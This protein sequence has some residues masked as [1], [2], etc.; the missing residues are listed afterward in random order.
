[1]HRY[2]FCPAAVLLACIAV[3]GA[4][5]QRP[6]VLFIAVDD[7]N[8]WVGVLGGHPQAKTPNIDRLA[9][10]GMLFT[11]AYC[12]APLCNPSRT[13][14]MTG[15]RP[16]TSGVHGNQQDW[17]EQPSLQG[18]VTLPQYFR[19]HGYRTLGCGKLYHANH[20]G[21]PGA[22][23]GWHGGRQGFNHPASWD[24]RFPS[25][26]VQLPLSSVAPGQ[27]YNGLDIWHWDW[28][29]IG[30]P[31]SAT[32]DG[33]TTAWAIEQLRK[34]H[35]RPFFLAVGIYRP[36]GPWYVPGAYFEQHPL[37]KTV[38][39]TVEPDD[40]KDIPAAG[41]R[42]LRNPNHLHKRILEHDLWHSA[43]QAYLANITFADAML[44]RVLDAL[45]ESG[46]RDNTII[47]LWSD[48]GWHLGEKQ[49]WHKSTLWEEAARV[50]LIFV[51]PGTTEPGS[52]CRR[53]VSLVDLYPTLVELCGLP[54]KWENDGLSLRPLLEDPS[55][56]REQPAITSH[57]GDNHAVRTERW[58][59]IRYA[60]GSEELYDH[61]SD[62]NEWTNLAGDPEHAAVKDRLSEW[63][64][65]VVVPYPPE[66]P[67]QEGR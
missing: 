48:H 59:Y 21:P 28:G 44:G 57:A 54:P 33:R 63:L 47:C 34:E 2:F 13:S 50:P 27:N 37:E 58:R 10:R 30:K 17:R 29:P 11:R 52:I 45:D 3:G 35:R 43:V 62:P 46:R 4:E 42:Y 7:L 19:A 18:A 16:T 20:G 9:K 15:L 55:R 1:M 25:K 22:L 67:E 14:V 39:P 8:D 24:E 53:T 12:A 23:T 49:R 66:K 41:L 60:D 64:P 26:E 61:R 65:E 5:P 38:L 56:A 36:H 51:V 40:V 6:N 31:D 32:I